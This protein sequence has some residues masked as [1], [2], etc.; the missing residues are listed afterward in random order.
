MKVELARQE[1]P[2]I[3]ITL[4]HGEAELLCRDPLPF[5]TNAVLSTLVRRVSEYV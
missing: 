4:T 2:D 3:V 5:L 1:K